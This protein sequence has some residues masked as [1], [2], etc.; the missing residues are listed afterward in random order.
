MSRLRLSVAMCTYNGAR[1]LQLQLDS[2]ASQSL[3]PDELVVCDDGSSD[4]TLIL[5]K[6]FAKKSPFP[7]RLHV[8]ESN[9]GATKNFEQ[10]IRLCT[11]DVIVLSDQDDIWRPKKLEVLYAALEMHPQAW[12]AFS[13]ADIIDDMGLPLRRSLWESVGFNAHAVKQ[14]LGGDQLAFL[15][16]R[17][18]VTGAGMA[19][20]AS[21]KEYFLPLPTGWIHDYW[22][23]LL[24]STFGYGLGIPDQLFSYRRHPVQ[25][26]G[27]CRTTFLQ[28]CR[29]SLAVTAEGLA[30]K[31]ERIRELEW[32]V[33]STNAIA[34]FP[35]ANI[36]LIRQK[37][38]H[39]ERRFSIRAK[40]GSPRVL[41][42]LVEALTGRYMKFSDL[43]WRS[44][45]RDL[46][47]CLTK[48]RVSK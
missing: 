42:F 31:V 33:M 23:A 28:D 36:D 48:S 25:Q 32:R 22:I 16:K 44:I 5:L 18:I 6:E 43:W 1:Y 10:A 46:L 37:T 15:L 47:S 45:T 26:I 14:F 21:F 39:L 27:T 13:D 8:N 11:G 9:L 24:G 7:V 17:N 41:T 12:Y 29:A 40:Q 35:S 19:I 4:D 3:F 2:I 34:V 20:R 30:A 38:L